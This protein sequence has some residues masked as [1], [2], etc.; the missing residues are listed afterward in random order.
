[1]LSLLDFLLKMLRLYTIVSMLTSADPGNVVWQPHPPLIYG[2]EPLE[3][4]RGIGKPKMADVVTERPKNWR[5][6]FSNKKDWCGALTGIG[7]LFE[8]FQK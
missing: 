3:N 5:E 4:Q 8:C 6:S 2:S 7:Q 1:M